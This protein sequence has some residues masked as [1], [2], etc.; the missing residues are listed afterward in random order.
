MKSKILKP[1]AVAT[2]MAMGLG[3]TA[4]AAS[5]T[6]T[7]DY[8]YGGDNPTLTVTTNIGGATSGS[9]VTFLVAN[10][11]VTDGSKIVYID[12]A[13]V[14]TDGTAE[15]VFKAAQDKLYANASVTAKFGT[16]NSANTDLN[17]FKFADGVDYITEANAQVKEL[18]AFNLDSEDDTTDKYVVYGQISGIVTEYGLKLE[19]DGETTKYFP[20]YA[21]EGGVFVVTVDKTDLDGWNASVYAKDAE[22][23]EVTPTADSTVNA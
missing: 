22:G 7:T 13:G 8:T 23:A 15:F 4:L 5:V 18:S 2:I 20:G 10:G 1:M 21:T 12:Q 9:Q 14:G 11:D 17:S 19:K 16:D 6:T 3:T